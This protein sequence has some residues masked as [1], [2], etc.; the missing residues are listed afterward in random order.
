MELVFAPARAVRGTVRVPGD[1]SVTHRA[2]LLAMVAAGTSRIRGANPGADCAATLAAVATLGAR[3]TRVDADTVAIEGHP[4]TLAAPGGS[5]DLGNSGTGMRLLAGLLAGRNVAVTLVGDTSLSGRPM[6]RI[7]EPLRALGARVTATGP[8]A[9][10]PLVIAAVDG[11]V[12]V[13]WHS[14]V[15]SAQVKS[16]V[17]L[18][19]LAARGTTTMREPAPSRDH[20]ERLLPAFGIACARPD[21]LTS[22]VTGPVVPHAAHVDVPGDF[23]AA[24]FWL[25]AATI[26]GEGELRLEAVGVNPTRTGALAVL[27]R[28]GADIELLRPRTVGDEPVA[29]LVVRPAALIATD[30][31]PEEIPALLDELPALAIAQ[32]VARGRS[33]VRGASELRVKESDRITHV[34]NGLRAIGGVAD[35]AP[36]GWSVT[37]GSLTGGAV[38][39]A[40][41]HRLAMAFGV[42]SLAAA[43]AVRVTGGA[44]IDTSYPGFYH[45]FKDRVLAR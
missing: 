17:L 39:A 33:T 8:R 42:A 27:R 36:D 2:Y 21:A 35:E 5:L 13:D 32:A 15:A 24:C 18:A 22:S 19:G 20:T 14:P 43:G 40:G 1:K 45:A 3:V 6:G 37:G 30:I 23:S 12:A 10:P 11:L 44:M 26:A 29:D 41:D 28:M 31:E 34:V 4:D 9:T 25:V 16:A 38:D 7:V